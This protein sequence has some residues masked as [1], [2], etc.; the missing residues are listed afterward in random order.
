MLA[1]LLALMR[2]ARRAILAEHST[3]AHAIAAL[4]DDDAVAGLEIRHIASSVLDDT[5]DLMTEN[6]RCFVERNDASVRIAI[7]VRV[8]GDDM[9]VGSAEPHSRNAHA[10]FMGRRRRRRDIAQLQLI[11]AGEEDGAHY[12]RSRVARSAQTAPMGNAYR[13]M[14]SRRISMLYPGRVGGT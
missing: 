11:H 9:D 14:L 6:L 13:S 1:V 10:N 3:L 2:V 5:G 8:A 4:V 12:R 7:V